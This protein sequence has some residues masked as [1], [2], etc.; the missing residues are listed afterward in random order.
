MVSYKGAGAG[1]LA[2]L[3]KKSQKWVALSDEQKVL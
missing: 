3:E 1:Y 2:F